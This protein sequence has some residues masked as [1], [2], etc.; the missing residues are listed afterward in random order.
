MKPSRK[1]VG[2]WRAI[3]KPKD[4]SIR[5]SDGERN[6]RKALVE[7]VSREAAIALIARH[8]NKVS[9]TRH[10]TWYATPRLWYAAPFGAGT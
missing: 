6:F 2:V 10:I 3:E 8:L 9:Q 4:L 7:N 5:S 1:T